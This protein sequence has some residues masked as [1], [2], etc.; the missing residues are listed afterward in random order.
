MS[1]RVG[2]DGICDIHIQ[3]LLYFIIFQKI[4]FLVMVVVVAA[5]A[6]AAVVPLQHIDTV[7]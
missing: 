5:A 6:A 4:N 2:Q 7:R 3:D 1:F